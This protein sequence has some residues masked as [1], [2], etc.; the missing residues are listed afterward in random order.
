M[1]HEFRSAHPASRVFA[2]YVDDV[3]RFASSL[4]MVAQVDLIASDDGEP[5]VGP[6]IRD[7]R[8][9]ADVS[10]LPQFIASRLPPSFFQWTTRCTWDPRTQSG[11][12]TLDI[13]VFGEGPHIVG[14]HHFDSDG[15][16]SRT[17][18]EG[19]VKVS[20]AGFDRLGGIP[21]GRPMQFAVDA[22]VHRVFSEIVGYSGK[23]VEAWLDR[24]V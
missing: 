7:H 14:A 11:T 5:G 23:V 24:S 9:Q 17:Q 8:W 16:G 18:V 22:L 4:P 21:I 20:A 3:P 13:G 10:R 1:I 19:E 12:W 6:L 2:A 15:T